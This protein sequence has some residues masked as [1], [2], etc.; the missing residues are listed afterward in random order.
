LEISRQET[1]SERAITKIQEEYSD[2][3]PTDMMS[4]FKLLESEGKAAL[5]LKMQ[6]G[7][8]RDLWL[9]SE[10]SEVKREG[11]RDERM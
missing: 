6:K 8:A 1:K 10:I 4:A 3:D 9:K 11:K 2:W 7:A 5:F